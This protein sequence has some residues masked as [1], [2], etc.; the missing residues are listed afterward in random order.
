[1]SQSTSDSRLDQSQSSHNS[2]SGRKNSKI[3]RFISKVSSFITKITPKKSTPLNTG[4]AVEILD[5][6]STPN[7]FKLMRQDRKGQYE[8]K[9]NK[10]KFNTNDDI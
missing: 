8:T 2:R 10:L 3:N 7:S 6:G 5:G 9:T 1:M 4:S